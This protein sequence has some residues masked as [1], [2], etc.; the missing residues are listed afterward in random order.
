VEL[1]LGLTHW[2]L[3]HGKWLGTGAKPWDSVFVIMRRSGFG[4]D[5]YIKPDFSFLRY[6]SWALGVGFGALKT[7]LAFLWYWDLV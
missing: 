5:F 3:R 2:E 7:D 4:A 1:G 6:G